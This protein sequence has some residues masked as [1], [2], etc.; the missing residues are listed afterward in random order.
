[1]YLNESISAGRIVSGGKINSLA[2]DFSVS[3][4]DPFTLFLKAKSGS[5]TS[6][7][8][9]VILAGSE[10]T[11][12]MPFKVDQWNEVLIIGLKA[13]ASILDTYDIYWGSGMDT[14]V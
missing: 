13:N 12:D 10:D 4:N 2:A 14:T 11:T 9:S 3:D 1:M 6:E 5:A 7:V 8:L